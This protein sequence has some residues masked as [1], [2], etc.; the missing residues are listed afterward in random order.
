MRRIPKD[1]WSMF[2]VCKW[3]SLG[4]SYLLDDEL[5]FQHNARVW[6]TDRQT[7]YGIGRIW[8]YAY[9]SHNKKVFVSMCLSVCVCLC[10]RVCVSMCVYVCV[11][12]VTAGCEFLYR[13]R[14]QS[15]DCVCQPCLWGTLLYTDIW[16]TIS[17][18]VSFVEVTNTT[19]LA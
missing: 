11:C 14:Q 17:S 12:V 15:S 18:T 16:C 3:E 7:L 8:H 4:Y 9:A 2:S 1:I 13:R 10:V 19:Y 6:Q 5:L